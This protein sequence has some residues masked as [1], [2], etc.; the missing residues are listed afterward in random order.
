MSF[1]AENFLFIG[2]ILVFVSI[3][4]SKTGHR[5]GVP[6]LLLFLF[7]G[8]LFG[9]DGIGLQFSNFDEAQYIGIFALTIILFSGGMDTDAKEIRPVAV[10]GIILSTVGVVLTM[11]I[12]GGFIYALVALF[13][14]GSPFPLGICML[15]AAVMSSTDSAS[16][17]SILRSKGL[18]LK[19]LLRPLLELESSSN[20]PMAYMLT[21]VLTQFVISNN[22]SVG[23]MIWMLV[24]QFVLG[25]ILGY[26]IGQIAVYVTNRINLDYAALYSIMFL[27][28]A[29]FTYSFT[30]MLYGNGF[31]A[32]YIAGLVVGNNTIMYKKSVMTFF[33]GIAWLMQIIMFLILGLL[34]NPKE[35]VD[36]TLISLA[37]GIFMM[38]VARPASVFLCLLPF[39][40][41]SKRG[42]LFISWVG[43]RGAVPIIFAI[44]PYIANVPYADKIFNIV[45]CITIVSLLVQG[46][47]ISYAARIMD[48]LRPAPAHKEFAV[49][50][51]EDM[52]VTSELHVTPGLLC[53]DCQPKLKD[54]PLSEHALIMMIKRDG[55]YFVPK[56]ESEI[57]TGDKLLIVA[58]TEETL[59]GTFEKL[60]IENYEIY[61]NK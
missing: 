46:S 7:V 61:K 32:V 6:S 8:M 21:A 2:S 16:V 4:A 54:V 14:G 28:F 39:K 11:F 55:K 25:I 38:A 45:F 1:T 35:L 9:S 33:D 37:I 47:T 53:D 19:P 22:L 31:L 27:A 26:V 57:M 29:L 52:A 49:E 15:L 42:K 13:H 40:K 23:I 51:P 36:V 58:D 10:E 30:N 12:T 59:R 17:F 56:E 43:L 5:F 34:V 18:H 20:D 41:F 3:L 24:I 48:L 60:G 50:I 44:M